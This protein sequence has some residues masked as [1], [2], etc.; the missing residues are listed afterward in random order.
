MFF[1]S[2]RVN[3]VLS[4]YLGPCG[5]G[6]PV[7]ESACKVTH[8]NTI[9]VKAGLT[10]E[11]DQLYNWKLMEKCFLSTHHPSLMVHPQGS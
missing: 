9:P 1:C 8:P 11:S 3:H 4:I 10:S 6:P 5:I 7:Y 2:S